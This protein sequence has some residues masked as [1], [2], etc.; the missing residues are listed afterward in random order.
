MLSVAY[1]WT[2]ET[3]TKATLQG[4]NQLIFS[5]GQNCCNLLP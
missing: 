5:G 4:R 1:L 2:R 3:S